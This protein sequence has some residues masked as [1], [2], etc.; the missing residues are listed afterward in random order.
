MEINNKLEFNSESLIWK[1]PKCARE[2]CN[3]E[4][5]ILFS[6]KLVCGECLHRINQKQND[7]FSKQLEELDDN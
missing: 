5:M 1:R 6:G 4:A 7:L 3:N 2:K